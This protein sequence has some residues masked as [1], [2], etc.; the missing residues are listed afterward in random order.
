MNDFVRGWF[1][2]GK[3]EERGSI[4]QFFCYF[5]AFNYLYD[6]YTKPDREKVK[7]L[8]KNEIISLFP[9][10]KASAILKDDA[11][12]YDEPERLNRGERAVNKLTSD[13]LLEEVFL[14]IYQVRCNLFHGSKAMD[15][16][17]DHRLVYTSAVTLEIFL[18]KWLDKARY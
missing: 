4:F 13:A 14:N 15:T 3:N 1:D 17:R 11:A 10:N 8:V 7:T 5:I 16:Q 9:V 2:R 12:F 6:R 18:E